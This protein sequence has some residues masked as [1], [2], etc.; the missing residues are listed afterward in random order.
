MNVSS[1][2]GGRREAK[3]KTGVAKAC[4]LTQCLCLI[5]NHRAYCFSLRTSFLRPRRLLVEIQLLL[6]H[7]SC[8]SM[9]WQSN[10]GV[11]GNPTEQLIGSADG[12]SLRA[13][14]KLTI[15]L[16]LH[17]ENTG[18]N[19]VQWLWL[20]QKHANPIRKGRV[21]YCLQT[22]I[23]VLTSLVFREKMTQYPLS[24]NTR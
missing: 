14:P 21:A 3:T 19:S 6:G 2:R 13:A 8:L 16:G 7:F 17:L 24:P 22:V 5:T 23:S 9:H 18:R 15:L 20:S 10:S 1:G 11:K 12:P 4:R